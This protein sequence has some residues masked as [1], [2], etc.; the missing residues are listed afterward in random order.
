MHMIQLL[1]KD[2]TVL[3]ELQKS[4]MFPDY[5]SVLLEAIAHKINI[6]GLYVDSEKIDGVVWRGVNLD[7]VSFFNC[8]MIKNS[9]FECSG[10]LQCFKCNLEQSKIKDSQFKS[11]DLSDCTLLNAS[12]RCSSIGRC[13]I[14][15]CN[16][17]NVLF[18]N[19]HFNNISFHFCN[20]TNVTY[21]ECILVTSDFVHKNEGSDWYYN[22]SFIKTRVS[23]C[24][25]SCINDLSQLFFWETNIEEF[26]FATHQRFTII[27]NNRSKVI[28]AI[29]SD[30]IWWKPFRRDEIHPYRHSIQEFLLEVNDRFPTTDV[31]PEMDDLDV[32]EELLAVCAYVSC[33]EKA[34]F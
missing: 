4:E 25:M 7:F 27:E 6:S 32:E 20:L 3:Y 9:F 29:D 17:G 24:N 18:N 22:M 15:D 1:T 34:D 28:F 21:Y 16:L 14:I 2:K 8:S 19:I 13:F 23:S 12:F 26:D 33:W 30:V 31:Y 5:C 11:V 10:N